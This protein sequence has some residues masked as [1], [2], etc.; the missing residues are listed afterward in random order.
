MGAG[1]EATMLADDLPLGDDGDA[2]RIHSN[3]DRAIGER[4]RHAVAIAFQVDQAGRRDALG[5][6]DEAVEWPGKLHQAPRFF[7]PG[8][9]DGARVRAVWRQRPQFPT[10]RLQ[11]VV[12]RRQGGEVGRGLPEP[13]A[14]ILDVLFDLPFLPTGR[15]IAE[16]GLEQEVADHG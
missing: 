10:S 2:F 8:V 6:F 16:L 3:A 14:R 13:M 5:V 11:P 4:R 7:G 1:E 15:R 12:Q 9:G